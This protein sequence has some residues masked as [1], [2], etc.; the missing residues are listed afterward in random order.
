MRHTKGRWAD[1]PIEWADWQ[2]RDWVRPIFGWFTPQAR[3]GVHRAYIECGKK[4]GK[5]T[6]ASAVATYMSLFIGEPG[7][8]VYCLAST[9]D[10]ARIVQQQIEHFVK[11][12]PVLAAAAHVHTS[13]KTRGGTIDW[14]QS[15]SKIEAMTGRGTSG[16]N[17][18]CVIMDELHEWKGRD[19]FERWTYGSLA[20]DGWL[21]LMITNAGDDLESVCYHQRELT[22]RVNAGTVDL[23]D[24]YGHVYGATREQ[25]EAEIESVAGGATRLPV[26]SRCNPGLGTI[27][28]EEDL[29]S[30]IKQALHI[31]A[32]MPNL[33]R[34]WYCVWR[35]AADV[36]WIG[37]YWDDCL[38]AYTLDEL[39][40]QPGWIGM[41]LSSVCDMSALVLVCVDDQ[42][43]C[44]QWPIFFV[45]RERAN[46]LRKWTA[47]EEWEKLGHIRVLPGHS[48]DQEALRETIAQLCETH[49][50]RGLVYDPKESTELSTWIDDYIG[51]ETM[52]FRQSHE[53]YHEPTDR[54]EAAVKE[55]RIKHPGNKVLSWQAKHANCVTT[56]HDRKKPLKPDSTGAPHKTVDG[57][58]AAVMAYSQ[59]MDYEAEREAFGVYAFT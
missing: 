31:P 28:R 17:P 1:H 43:V 52:P 59:A 11:N 2:R 4:S 53:N 19:S 23:P 9:G 14:P 48:I 33:L 34:F 8:E 20:R 38:E 21:H 55:N 58:Q 46:D 25:A 41:D 29:I 12:N 54:Y 45:P 35:T 32:N 51:I 40:G 26:A 49:D 3:R 13:S 57:I 36:E 50:I 47:I 39:Q 24:Y 27:L 6:F 10:Q 15:N 37:P 30:E 5:S 42:Q 7:S 44:R 18:M 56:T 22:L 16:F